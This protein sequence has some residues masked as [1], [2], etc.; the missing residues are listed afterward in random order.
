MECEY[1]RDSTGRVS[2]LE[3]MVVLVSLLLTDIYSM[4]LFRIQ[5]EVLKIMPDYFTR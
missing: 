1:K 5:K 2:G 4:T 3:A